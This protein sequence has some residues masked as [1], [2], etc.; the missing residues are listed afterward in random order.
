M[1]RFSANLGFLWTELSLPDAIRAAASAGFSAVE[2]HW[3]YATPAA[4]V[5]AA[6]QETGLTMLGLNTQRGNVANGDNG[7]AAITGRESEARLFI[8]EAIAYAA[9]INCPNVHVMAGFTDRKAQA[10]RTFCDNLTYACE[11]AKP[12]DITILIEPLNHYDAPSYHLSTLDGAMETLNSV[13]NDQLKIMFDCYHLQIMHGD[14]LR[15]LE[16]HL[17]H[18]GHIQIASV[19]DRSEPHNGEVHYRNLLTAV[20]AMGWCG[21]IGAE[22][23]PRGTTEEGLDWLKAYPA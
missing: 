10:Q 17:P 19:P 16:Q 9:K 22:Y 4:D 13:N 8:E 12:Q 15:R 5:N 1:I 6:L 23:K 7:V 20:D 2:C 11:L 21:Y 18:I 14:L 3:P